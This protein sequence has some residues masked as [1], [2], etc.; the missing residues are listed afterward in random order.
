MKIR[1][2]ILPALLGLA[3]TVGG[4]TA[5][6]KYSS[7][8]ADSAAKELGVDLLVFGYAPEEVL[9][10]DEEADKLGQNHFDLIEKILN[11]V[12]YGLNATKKPII[13]ELLNKQGDVVYCEQ[14]VQGGNLKHILIDGT[15]AYG[16]L[17]Q[18][19]YVSDTE[20]I[21]YTYIVGDVKNKPIGTEIDVYKTVMTTNE[22][23][24][25]NAPTSYYGKAPIVSVRT[26]NS[27]VRAINSKAWTNA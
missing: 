3:L 18:I 16:L 12:S 14:N 26:S 1:M 6:W 13:H 27:T 8:P 5:T 22:K 24:V 11:E 10:D 17:F 2:R 20:Y 21:T 15:S 9:P 23:G 4:V 19:E 7:G 25:W